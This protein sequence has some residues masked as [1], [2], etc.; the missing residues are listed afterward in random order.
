[1]VIGI[2]QFNWESAALKRLAS[3]GSI[4]SLA[5]MFSI[6]YRQSKSQFHSVSFQKLWSAEIRISDGTGGRIVPECS[7]FR[8]PADSA[9]RKTTDVVP[10]AHR[11]S[12]SARRRSRRRTTGGGRRNWPPGIRLREE[13]EMGRSGSLDDAFLCSSRRATAGAA[14]D[15]R[16]K[17]GLRSCRLQD[18]ARP[19]DSCS[20]VGVKPNSLRLFQ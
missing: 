13:G 16:R 7:L 17:A 3:G 15:Q 1:M 9:P 10:S 14:E 8:A 6:A 20:F 11:A 2:Q 19:S 5:T 4:P 18:D 12:P